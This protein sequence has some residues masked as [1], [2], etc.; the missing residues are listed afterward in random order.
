MNKEDLS[1]FYGYGPSREADSFELASHYLG[2]KMYQCL[3]TGGHI[4]D[5]RTKHECAFRVDQARALLSDTLESD[6][7]APDAVLDAAALMIMA[8]VDAVMVSMPEA[9]SDDIM[10]QLGKRLYAQSGHWYNTEVRKGHV[11]AGTYGDDADE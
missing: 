1:K 10:Y 7:A 3:I 11:T 6:D 2:S 4:H 8:A 9:A 5:G